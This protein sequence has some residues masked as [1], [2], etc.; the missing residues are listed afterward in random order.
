MNIT[1]AAGHATG[2]IFRRH[3]HT[4]VANLTLLFTNMGKD[5]IKYF[6]K[7][8]TGAVDLWAMHNFINITN[9]CTYTKL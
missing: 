9:S 4:F 5:P 8:I 6:L 3:L 2:P 1:K 7:N